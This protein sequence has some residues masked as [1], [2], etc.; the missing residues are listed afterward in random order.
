MIDNQ[1][2]NNDKILYAD[3]LLLLNINNKII[4]A[5]IKM[6]SDLE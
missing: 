2:I 6:I 5:I 1:L 3:F 4:F